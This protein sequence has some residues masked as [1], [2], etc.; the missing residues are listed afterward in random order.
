[1]TILSSKTDIAH[2]MAHGVRPADLATRVKARLRTLRS[3]LERR[4]AIIDA[5]RQANATLDPEKVAKWL[6]AQAAEWLPAPCWA[7]I[8]HD[9]SG[10]VAVIADDGLTPSL[11]P[12]LWTAANWVIRKGEE[13]S[14]ADLARD[15]RAQKNAVGTA[16]AFPLIC[17]N[18]TVGVLVGLDPEPSSSAP[19]L[20]AAVALTL[21]TVLEPAAIALDNA[22]ALQNAEALSV[23]DDLTRL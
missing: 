2:T 15:P 6:V 11:G 19:A 9:M 12:S 3:Q 10:D 20:G 18:R 14:A 23:P 7:V 1:V 17:R 4:D 21:G 16:I 5:V 13:F 8:A 22:I